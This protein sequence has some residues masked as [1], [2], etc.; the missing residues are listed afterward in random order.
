M[1][2]LPLASSLVL[3]L[4]RL[5]LSSSIPIDNLDSNSLLFDNSQ[6]LT[7]LAGDNDFLT[8]DTTLSNPCATGQD[9]LSFTQEEGTTLF[10]RDDHP[11]CLPPV[12]IGADA[13][14][15]FE[16]PLDSLA[17][18][19]LP[20]KGE[21]PQNPPPLKYPGLL[22]DGEI[23]GD[24]DSEDMENQ[25]WQP[26]GGSVRIE[27]SDDNS[28][29]KLAAGRGNFNIELCCNAIYVGYGARS[30]LARD[31]IAQID[32]VTVANQDIAVIFN[33]ICTFFSY[34]YIKFFDRGDLD[35][36][37][38]IPF[39]IVDANIDLIRQSP[40]RTGLALTIIQYTVSAA[41]RM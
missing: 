40:L 38:K 16:S 31:R 17:N 9:D 32:P 18:T 36:F 41:V 12:N 3:F 37:P 28:C 22:P 29:P 11:Q 15:L 39:K 27:S 7:F 23:G 34:I 35:F 19:L 8:A 2:S 14:Q 30:P 21:T 33:C 5:V 20:L 13:L 24:H 6:P 10:S 4:G 1:Y 25:G 26:Y